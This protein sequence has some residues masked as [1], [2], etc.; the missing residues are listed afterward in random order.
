MKE[1][2][3]ITR[4]DGC[5]SWEEYAIEANTAEDAKEAVSQGAGSLVGGE[6]NAMPVVSAEE[7]K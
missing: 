4:C 1:W 7:N 2:I 3:V 6:T 5:G